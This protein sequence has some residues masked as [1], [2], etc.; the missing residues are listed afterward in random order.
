MTVESKVD[1]ILSLYLNFGDSDYIG[2]PISQME[3][4]YQ[5]AQL[6]QE[7]NA[8]GEL[9][10]AAFFHDIGHLYEYA[11]PEENLLNMDG[12]GIFDHE[13]IGAQYLK[14]MGFSEKISKLVASH[15]QAKR[16]LAFKNPTYLNELSEASLKT[17]SFQGGVMS[18]EEAIEFESDLLFDQFIML[19]MWDEK[20]KETNKSVGDINFIKELMIKHLTITN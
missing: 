4:M 2:E 9:I 11:F 6:A 7:A 12:Y 17:L 15:V 10:L 1:E 14:T 3:H 5:C 8:D 13:N 16:Y 20:A 18:E 19:R